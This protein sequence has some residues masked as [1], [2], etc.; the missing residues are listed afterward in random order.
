MNEARLLIAADAIQPA[1]R[2]HVRAAA[3]RGGR[4]GRLRR[5]ARSQAFFSVSSARNP[6]ISTDSRKFFATFGK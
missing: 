2:G 5:L 3:L 6:L 4:Q 1:R